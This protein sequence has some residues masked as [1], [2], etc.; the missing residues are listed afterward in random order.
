MYKSFMLDRMSVDGRFVRVCSSLMGTKGSVSASAYW[1]EPD[2]VHID[3]SN[4]Q[5]LRGNIAIVRKGACTYLSK[6]LRV[7]EAGAIGMIVLLPGSDNLVCPAASSHE[8]EASK[9]L[10]IQIVTVGANGG[11]LLVNGASV[12][13][14]LSG[15]KTEDQPAS[16][17]SSQPA[18]TLLGCYVDEVATSTST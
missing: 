13:W 17:L 7:Q 14:S 10:T 6:A 18:S 15:G 12:T 8:E 9:N 4:K 3:L 16:K 2:Q 1:A 5:Q 11:A